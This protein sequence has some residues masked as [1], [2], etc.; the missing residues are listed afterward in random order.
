[1]NYACAFSNVFLL[2]LHVDALVPEERVLFRMEFI[3]F[4]ELVYCTL[5]KIS[6]V[7]I[8]SESFM[9]FFF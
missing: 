5:A 2:S 4:R 8:F 3:F 6:F 7:N 1:M 9:V